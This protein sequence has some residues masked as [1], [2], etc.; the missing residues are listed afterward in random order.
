MLQAALYFKAG[1]RCNAHAFEPFYNGALLAYRQGDLQ[2]A[3]TQVRISELSP[4]YKHGDMA[5]HGVI[6]QGHVL[7]MHVGMPSCS[8]STRNHGSVVDSAQIAIKCRDN[9]TLP[10]LCN[11]CWAMYDRL[12]Q[13]HSSSYVALA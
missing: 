13:R 3:W 6:L 5:A 12:N 10:I 9:V 4:V 8:V 7:G 11:Y 2:E 1:Q